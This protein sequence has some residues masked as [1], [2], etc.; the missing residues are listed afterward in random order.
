MASASPALTP[1]PFAEAICK[2]LADV[3]ARTFGSSWTADTQSQDAS[4]STDTKPISFGISVSG[5]FQGLAA[6]R[7]TPSD[8]GLLVQNF[9]DPPLTELSEE[10]NQSLL[11][12][13][14]EITAKATSLLESQF[15]SV[16]LEVSSIEEP[17]WQSTGMVLRV[18]DATR[19]AV[20]L[21]LLISNELMQAMAA[22][23]AGTIESEENV[24]AGNTN[25]DL[26]RGV[27]LTLTL[28]FG[29]RTL[30]L[31]EILDLTSGSVVELDRQ[32]QEPADLLL[33]DKLIARGEVVIVD[34]NYGLRITEL[35]DQ[36]QSVA[37]NNA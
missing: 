37:R 16:A 5:A 11:T 1:H 10:Q 32:V 17:T 9:S 7:L 25:L 30:S 34:G 35:P 6:I 15:G 8:A 18:S 36:S 29:T 27:D 33:G 12:L 21:Y 14:Q 3:F 20:T 31:R 2:A 28:R 24:I 22:D 4:A 26:L 19:R 13:L 23:P